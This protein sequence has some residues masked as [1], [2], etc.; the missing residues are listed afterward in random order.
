MLVGVAWLQQRFAQVQG[1]SLEEFL[2]A[3]ERTVHNQKSERN[4][5]AE[6]AV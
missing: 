2:V 4:K 6:M 5:L 3:L 1:V